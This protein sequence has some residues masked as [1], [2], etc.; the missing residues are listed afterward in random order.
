MVRQ[1]NEKIDRELLNRLREG[2]EAAF[3]TI[4]RQYNAWIYNFANS[5]L[6]DK[7]LTEDLTQNVFL[8]IWE[9]HEQINPDDNFESY[10]FTIARNLV[11]KETENRLLAERLVEAL[12]SQQS[13]EDNSTEMQ[14]DNESL[15]EYINVLIEQLPPAR[16]NIYKLSRLQFLSN[17]EIAEK[18]SI[19]EKTVEAQ[20]THSLKFLKKKLANNIGILILLA[21]AFVK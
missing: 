3:E 11:F 12:R 6:F 14:I 17:K 4:Y 20:I 13:D 7:S 9:K 10:L 5:L 1:S 16:R 15:K 21:L 8:K 18:L 2:D 19:S